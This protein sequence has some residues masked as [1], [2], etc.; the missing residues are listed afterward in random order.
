VCGKSVLYFC[1]TLVFSHKN[2]FKNLYKGAIYL[3]RKKKLYLFSF[4]FISAL[5]FCFYGWNIL[6]DKQE[7]IVDINKI[8]QIEF[9][10]PENSINQGTSFTCKLSLG[11]MKQYDHVYAWQEKNSIYI[12]F[13][14]TIS[15]SFS[16]NQTITD[17]FSTLMN[18]SKDDEIE[19]IYL[20]SGSTIFD[21]NNGVNPKK[22]T[23]NKLVWKKGG[24]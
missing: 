4:L 24:I 3:S 12:A 15:L 14:Q 5:I 7:T 16:E 19:K 18:S 10:A 13:S 9:S 23:K 1:L 22:Y 6:K 11:K 2:D 17:S 20:V 8:E 21:E